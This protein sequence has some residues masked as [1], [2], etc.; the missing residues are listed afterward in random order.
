MS[1]LQRKD[2]KL[3]SLDRVEYLLARRSD[4]GEVVEVG[5]GAACQRVQRRAPPLSLILLSDYGSRFRGEGIGLWVY[6]VGCRV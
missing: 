3:V 6:G 2:P 5:V 1:T 4:A